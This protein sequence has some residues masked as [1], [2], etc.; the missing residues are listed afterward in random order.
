MV[1]YI[2]ENICL[3]Q[4]KSKLSFFLQIFIFL[5]SVAFAEYKKSKSIGYFIY[6]VCS[7]FLVEIVIDLLILFYIHIDWF[8]YLFDRLEISINWIIL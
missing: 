6:N 7:L 5:I 8:A 2:Y 3:F 1:L 4:K